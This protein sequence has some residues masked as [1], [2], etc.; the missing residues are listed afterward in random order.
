MI[1]TTGDEAVATDY[2]VLTPGMRRML[3]A[4]SVLVFLIGIPLYLLS[5][6]TESFFAW[7]IPSALTA[8]F[9][10]GAY[11]SSCALEFLA[12]RERL[13]ARARIAVPAVLLFTFLTLIVTLLHLEKFHFDSPGLHTRAGTWAW[14]LVY[15]LVPVLMGALLL[16]QRALR[17]LEP[18][19]NDPLPGW[20]RGLLLLQALV[21]FPL[22][23]ALFL[24]PQVTAPIWPWSLAPLVAQAI[25]AWLLS[26][27]VIAAHAAW[28]NDWQRIRSFTASYAL[29]ALLQLL[30]LVRFGA[31]VEWDRPAAWFYL[32]FLISILLVGFVGVRRAMEHDSR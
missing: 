7:T 27:G 15:A 13:W 18:P 31:E 21:M 17:G 16:R 6:Q 26:I 20:V 4:A 10:G 5:R 19:Q 14:L 25:G 2:K 8:A 23:V 28:E 29:L 11:W 12:S 9:L 22:G 24:A 30:A 3:L 32:F 1:E